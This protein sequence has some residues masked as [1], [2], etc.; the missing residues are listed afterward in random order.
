MFDCLSFPFVVHEV[1]HGKHRIPSGYLAFFFVKL[2][3][4]VVSEVCGFAHV[5]FVKLHVVWLQTHAAHHAVIL[6]VSMLKSAISANYCAAVLLCAL[7]LRIDMIS[8]ST[9]FLY[10]R[11][12]TGFRRF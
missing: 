11:L 1:K 6:R 2:G 9:D 4:G 3:R 7:L 10:C 5:R 12:L 8:V